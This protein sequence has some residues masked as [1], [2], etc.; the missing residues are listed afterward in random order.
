[1]AEPG[2]RLVDRGVR[3]EF[4]TA[5]HEAKSEVK[6]CVHVQVRVDVG[7]RRAVLLAGESSGVE[8]R[9][10]DCG[11]GVRDELAA[12]SVEVDAARELLDPLGYGE[13][14]VSNRNAWLGCSW[15]RGTSGDARRHLE[16]ICYEAGQV[17]RVWL[18]LWR[19]RVW[20]GS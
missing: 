11:R 12:R 10:L 14:K 13:R 9:E 15:R 1:M 7:R 8:R 18:P 2:G 16:G 4:T 17:I 5:S 3:G 6:T 20:Y 19:R